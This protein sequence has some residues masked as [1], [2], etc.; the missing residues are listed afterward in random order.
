MENVLLR[1]VFAGLV[2]VGLAAGA[3]AQGSTT[4][5]EPAAPLLPQSF[6]Q[7]KIGSAAAT[8]TSSPASLVNVS[9]DALEE[10]GPQRSQVADYT[11]DGRTLHV[12]AIQFGDRTG[13]FSAYTLVKRPEMSSAKELGSAAAVGED[14]VLFT[15]GTSVVVA[16]PATEDDLAGL[17]PLAAVMPKT[18]GNQGVAPLLPTLLPAQGLVEGSVRYALGAAS[19]SA[20][21]GVLP[22]GALAWDKS[23]ESVTAQYKDKRGDETLTMLMYPTPEIAGAATRTVQSLVNAAGAPYANARVRREGELVM[24]A[25]GTF[26]PDEAQHVI[27]NIHLKQQLSVDN[28]MAPGTHFQILQT[29]S[30]LTNIAILSAILMSAAVL[31]GLFLGGGRAAYRVMRGKPAATEPEFLSLHLDPKNKPVRFERGRD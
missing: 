11:H 5:T 18:V 23:A 15:V 8:G 10:A 22:A 28:D 16:Y 31:L 3:V 27:E 24:L 14:A 2:M 26:A 30:L 9:K 12:E 7:W 19:Y 17:K 4:V 25:S 6:G 20:E 1:R 29:Y 13:A 21:G